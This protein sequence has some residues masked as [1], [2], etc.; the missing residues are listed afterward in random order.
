MQTVYGLTVI[1]TVKTFDSKVYRWREFQCWLLILVL[2][3][4]TFSKSLLCVEV[5]RIY[6]APH[7]LSWYNI[8]NFIISIWSLTPPTV[9]HRSAKVVPHSSY[10]RGTENIQSIKSS[11]FIIKT[12]SSKWKSFQCWLFSLQWHQPIH[13][14]HSKNQFQSNTALLKTATIVPDHSTTISVQEQAELSALQCIIN[15]AAAT[16]TSSEAREF[17]SKL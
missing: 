7:W 13:I 16:F 6:L 8:V 12:K 17:S 2:A 9:G 4:P 14:K 11:S 15:Q 1:K 3:Y 5:T 10:I